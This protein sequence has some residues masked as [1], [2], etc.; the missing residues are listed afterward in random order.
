MLEGPW[1]LSYEQQRTTLNSSK[2]VNSNNGN[3]RC[4]GDQGWKTQPVM[5]RSLLGG[6][7][8]LASWHSGLWSRMMKLPPASLVSPSEAWGGIAHLSKLGLRPLLAAGHLSDGKCYEGPAGL[9]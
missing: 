1:I 6:P 4:F 7:A 9:K 5:P 3:C 2:G 8:N